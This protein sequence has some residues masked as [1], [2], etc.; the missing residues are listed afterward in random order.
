[1]VVDKAI[2]GG[3]RCDHLLF[4]TRAPTSRSGSR[5]ATRPWPRRYVV[6]ETDTPARLS[7]TSVLSDW[8]EAPAVDD[9][10]FAFVPPA[11]T[12]QTRWIPYGTTGKSDR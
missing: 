4:A 10:Q 9:A 3:V 5:R 11:G 8:N 6:T 1:M 7:I 2:I 12:Q